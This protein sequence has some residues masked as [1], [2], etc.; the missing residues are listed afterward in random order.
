MAKRMITTEF[1]VEDSSIE[2]S[3]R[4][5]MLDDYIGQKK[6]KENL[7]VFSRHQLGALREG[8]KREQH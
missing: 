8:G 4:P 3:L 1:T 2:G 6:A 5:Q 7:S